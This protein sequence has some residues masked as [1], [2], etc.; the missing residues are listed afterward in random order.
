MT[1]GADRV[2][3]RRR[4]AEQRHRAG[5]ARPDRPPVRRRGTGRATAPT[6][7]RGCRYP[8]SAAPSASPAVG[9][10][11]G[12]P[13]DAFPAARQ[14]GQRLRVAHRP[15]HRRALARPGGRRGASSSRPAPRCRGTSTRTPSDHA[16]PAARAWRSA[17]VE[18]A[19]RAAVVT[20]VDR[21]Q[22]GRRERTGHPDVITGRP[23]QLGRLPGGGRGGGEVA[24]QHGQ[25]GQRCPAPAPARPVAPASPGRPSRG[26]GSATGGPPGSGRA[27]PTTDTAIRPGVPPWPRRRRSTQP[28]QRGPDVAV[29]VLQP[30]QPDRLLRA[31]PRRAGRPHHRQHVRPRAGRASRRLVRTRARRCQP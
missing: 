2:T 22:T 20:G 1:R 4:R 23:A 10:V 17:S 28:L 13:R 18:D 3:Q 24:L 11:T 25:S 29:L 6:R 30:P 8:R 15:Q 31:L 12:P 9:R 5:R 26:R 21:H 27:G 14:R 7:G 19:G 16:A